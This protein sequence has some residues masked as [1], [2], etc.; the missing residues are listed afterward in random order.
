MVPERTE[1]VVSYVIDGQEDFVSLGERGTVA[2]GIVP[3]LADCL[4]DNLK[5]LGDRLAVV[6]ALNL[7]TV[8][9]E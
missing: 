2:D 7:S 6:G 5:G 8:T 4:Q 9:R 3:P 1:D